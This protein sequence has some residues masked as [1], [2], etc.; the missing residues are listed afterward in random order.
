MMQRLRI[1]LAS[2]E[3]TEHAEKFESR[4]VTDSILDQLADSDL[5][6]IGIVKLGERKR[7]LSAFRK[8]ADS[9][10]APEDAL[11]IDEESEP[12]DVSEEQ[13]P[14]EIPEPPLDEQDSEKIIPFEKA[15]EDAS[16]DEP[17]PAP[18]PKKR[19]ASAK[20]KKNP[21]APRVAPAE[22]SLTSPKVSIQA[23]APAPRPKERAKRKPKK[24]PQNTPVSTPEASENRGESIGPGEVEEQTESSNSKSM[25]TALLL[26]LLFGP[27][28][29]LYISFGR[30]LFFLTLFVLAWIFG[31]LHF[32][33]GLTLWTLAPIASIL[34]FGA[35]K[36]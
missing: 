6:E 21:V 26:A 2:E 25:G 12:E 16:V 33:L 11:E 23:Q 8:P 7:L 24:S 15:S 20:K 5:R 9:W 1:I 32:V 34:L 4:G 18:K 14:F 30:A 35:G 27:I 36:R 10:S 13:I 3:L 19:P 22:E 29:L 28:G 31:L 17:E